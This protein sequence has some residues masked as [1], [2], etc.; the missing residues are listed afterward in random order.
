MLFA[1]LGASNKVEVF[2]EEFGKSFRGV[3]VAR[4]RAQQPMTSRRIWKTHG[5]GRIT[6]WQRLAKA[7]G[8]CDGGCTGERLVFALHEHK[9]AQ[10]Q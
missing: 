5:S 9:Q 8:L 7:A 10:M 2:S 4:L 1:K 6:G 3:R